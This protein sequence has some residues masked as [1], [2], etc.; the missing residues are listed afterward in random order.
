MRSASSEA[1]YCGRL[2]LCSIAPPRCD[3][4]DI[5]RQLE[6]WSILKKNYDLLAKEEMFG[7]NATTL[8]VLKRK[9]EAK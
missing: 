9:S 2:P 7:Q 6:Y 3:E 1:V 5:E 4:V 8:L